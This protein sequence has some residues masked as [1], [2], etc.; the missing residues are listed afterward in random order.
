[1]GKGEAEERELEGEER[2]R[3]RDGE[4]LAGEY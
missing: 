2:G 3:W 1:V 4:G